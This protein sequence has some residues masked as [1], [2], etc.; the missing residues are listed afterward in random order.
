MNNDELTQNTL[1][2]SD[3]E[4]Q[5]TML[6]IEL[7]PP[8]NEPIPKGIQE[9]TSTS[10]KKKRKTSRSQSTK[11]D[12]STRRVLHRIHKYVKNTDKLLKQLIKQMIHASQK[13]GRP[14]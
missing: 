11:S 2:D 3:I 12:S 6:P 9:E 1:V 4:S 7:P 13:H 8:T 10:T 14:I 5:K